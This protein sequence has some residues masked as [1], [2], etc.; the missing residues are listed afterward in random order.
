MDV[1]VIERNGL[2]PGTPDLRA[3]GPLAFGPDGVLF[4]AD[5]V[6][7]SIFA[8]AVDDPGD[9]VG[10]IDIDHLDTRLAALLGCA[11]DDVVI[12]D[13]AIHPVSGAAYLSIMRG[14]GSDAVPI[15][16]RAGRDG[17]LTAVPLT[18]GAIR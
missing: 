7:A 4:V 15:L 5:N 12:R 2:A 1:Q 10:P 3:A 6:S 13:L 16:V 18:D 14:H 17:S 11:L 9:G 8:I